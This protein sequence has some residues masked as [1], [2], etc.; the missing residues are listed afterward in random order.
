MPNDLS[1]R[2]HAL[3]YILQDIGRYAEQIVGLPLRSYQ[4]APARAIVDSVLHKKGLTFTVEMSRQAGKNEVSA[5]VEAYLMTLFKRKGGSIV[6]AAPTWK[7]QV[8]NSILRVQ[9]ILGNELTGDLW[10]AQFG[11]IIAV[12][13]ART[14]YFSAAP[15]S[16]IVG[17]TAS[18][19][20]EVDEAQD[21]DP[22]KYSKDLA[23]MAASTN[24]TRVFYGTAWTDDDLLQQQIAT[25]QRLQAQDG[26]QRHFA[27]P[28]HL[29]AAENPSYRAY[30]Q[31]EIA[32]L[33]ED[34]PLIRTQYLLLTLT[35]GGRLFTAAQLAQLQGTHFR[36]RKPQP[37]ARYVAGID[38]AGESEA[39]EDGQLRSLQPQK[40]STTV[41][42]AEVTWQ[43][44]AG[45]SVAKLQV[46]EQYLWTGR[47]H[48][49]L[50]PQ[51][52][53]LLKHVW[54]VQACVV[55]STGIGAGVA[56]FLVGA[57]G[58]DR[59][60]PFVFNSSSKSALG[61]QLISAVNAGGVKLYQPDHSEEHTLT[62][63]QF[64]LAKA[65]YRANNL[66]AWS[67]PESEGHDDLLISVALTV[68]AAKHSQP[69]YAV[70]RKLQEDR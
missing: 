10:A 8:V 13:K 48:R 59:V 5:Q 67:V 66:M 58:E 22:D 41:T 64:A 31:A 17:A 49:E 47:K 32:R 28:W 3:A 4:L 16:N 69:R 51:L 19:L 25:N 1:P 68:E 61:Y 60:F 45:A 57:L 38:V 43:E 34:H 30:V 36:T 15:E 42:L 54:Q 70:G 40:D 55:D 6:K 62:V 12:G 20:L 2:E 33:G 50:V 14:F 44:V 7:P 65:T 53:D 56:S 52:V 18:L 35:Q 11:Y 46:V 21:V 24:A 29:V 9:K 37:A 26:I 23:P 27:Y 39:A 63:R